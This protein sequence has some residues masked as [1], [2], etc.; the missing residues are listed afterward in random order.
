MRIADS[1]FVLS[2]TDLSNFLS[3][4]HRTALE[5]AEAHG[6]RR[7][8]RWDDPLLELLDLFARQRRVQLVL[9]SRQL[10]ERLPEAESATVYATD[11]YEQSVANLA[12]TS[13]DSDNVFGDGYSLQLAKVTGTVADGMV[14]T[15]NVP[16]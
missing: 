5:M 13:L 12:R 15:L 7:R 8:P 16:V 2:A 4:R 1:A 11:G 14:A 3:C 10:G 6:R 9:L